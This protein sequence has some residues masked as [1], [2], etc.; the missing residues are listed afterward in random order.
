MKKLIIG[1]FFGSFILAECPDGFYE[2]DC[3]NCWMSYCYTLFEF[4]MHT[5]YFDM[6]EEDCLSQGYMY[7]TPGDSG[8]PYY[9]SNCPEDACSECMESCVSY[10]MENY[11]YSEEDATYW[12]STTPDSQ[13]GCADSCSDDISD[14]EIDDDCEVVGKFSVKL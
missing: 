12:C 5:T 9:N 3:G 10:V 8:D 2:D 7:V 6:N 4:P 1:I 14:C 11:G 13:Y